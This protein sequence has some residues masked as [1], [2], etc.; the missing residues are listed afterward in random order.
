MGEKQVG[1]EFTCQNCG[2]C[3][4]PIGVN[5]DEWRLIR[6]QIRK[7]GID[8]TSKLMTQ[9][10]ED[11][12]C[13]FRDTEENKCAIYEAR[14]QI[15][16]MQGYYEGLPCPSQPQFATKDRRQGRLTLNTGAEFLGVIGMTLG[17]DDVL[18]GVPA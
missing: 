14:P 11:L 15:C 9:K 3:C 1:I 7:L 8:Y 13:I 16:R 17:W 18:R 2:A 10:R 4:G 5:T 6:R 12:T